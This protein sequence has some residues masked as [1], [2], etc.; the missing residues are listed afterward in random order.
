MPKPLQGVCHDKKLIHVPF[1][2]AP[3]PS[4]VPIYIPPQNFWK[5]KAPF[6][7]QWRVLGVVPSKVQLWSFSKVLD[8]LLGV[9]VIS[10]STVYQSGT[11]LVSNRVV[12]SSV[13]WWQ[14]IWSAMNGVIAWSENVANCK[15]TRQ[16]CVSS[17]TTCSRQM[18]TW[19]ISVAIIWDLLE[20][21][22]KILTTYADVRQHE[23]SPV[24]A[25][26]RIAD[27]RGVS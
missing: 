12:K 11:L 23:C 15:I 3:P 13:D 8:P 16:D 4:H 10:D 1:Q 18:W 21:Q 2:R 25:K 19:L 14:K 17:L 9:K 22:R 27:Q 20:T 24:W 7:E 6:G 5:T 26:S